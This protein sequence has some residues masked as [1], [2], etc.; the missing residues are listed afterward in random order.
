[1]GEIKEICII[2]FF[3]ILTFIST[4]Y[5]LWE[6]STTQPGYMKFG[7]LSKEEF[8]KNSDTNYLML[9]GFKI[10]LKY[11]ETC[12]ILR[13]PRSFHCGICGFCVL[14]HGKVKKNS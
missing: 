13:E 12:A 14:K 7:S 4:I 8:I 3:T 5:Y 2:Y 9:K 11:C 10:N 6:V 1:M